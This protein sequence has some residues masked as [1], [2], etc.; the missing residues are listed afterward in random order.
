MSNWGLI[1]KPDKI[2]VLNKDPKLWIEYANV[3]SQSGVVLPGHLANLRK[4]KEIAEQ[5]MEALRK[6]YF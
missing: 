4:Q 5:L 6:E 1:P 2:L 3:V